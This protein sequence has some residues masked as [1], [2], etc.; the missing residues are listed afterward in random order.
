MLVTAVQTGAPKLTQTA[1][2]ALRGFIL[3]YTDQPLG[4]G[5]VVTIHERRTERPAFLLGIPAR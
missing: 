1:V 4:A 2:W 3:D 5:D